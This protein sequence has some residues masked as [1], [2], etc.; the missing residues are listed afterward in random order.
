[1][2]WKTKLKI[3]ISINLEVLNN[4]SNYK[5]FDVFMIIHNGLGY[6]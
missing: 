6:A 5:L 3:F 1:M 4:S 2:K